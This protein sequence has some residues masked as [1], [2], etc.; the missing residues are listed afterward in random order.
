MNSISLKATIEDAISAVA[1]F[2]GKDEADI[3]EWPILKLTNRQQSYQR[4]RDYVICGIGQMYGT[5]WKGGNP[6]PSPFFDRADEGGFG[7]HMALGDFAGGAGERAI[8]NA[9]QQ[10]S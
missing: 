7:A 9:G 3:E 1:A 5:T 8:R 2:T 6:H 4:M 10:V